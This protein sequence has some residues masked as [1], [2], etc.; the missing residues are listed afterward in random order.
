MASTGARKP[1]QVRGVAAGGEWV[2][3][4]S[5]VLRDAEAFRRFAR[6]AEGEGAFPVRWGHLSPA[7]PFISGKDVVG[8][9]W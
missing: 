1:A 5:W 7:V 6:R 4:P 9:F 3:C 8:V 2:A